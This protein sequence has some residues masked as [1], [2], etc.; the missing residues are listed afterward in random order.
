MSR[1]YQG[2]IENNESKRVCKHH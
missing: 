1:V 2:F